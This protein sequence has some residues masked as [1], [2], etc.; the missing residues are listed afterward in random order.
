VPS[1]ASSTGPWFEAST[2]VEPLTE[3]A[4]PFPVA[5]APDEEL[6]PSLAPSKLEP[7]VAASAVSDAAADNPAPWDPAGCAT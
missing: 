5:A 7:D 1:T 2:T 3:L 4:S 6:F